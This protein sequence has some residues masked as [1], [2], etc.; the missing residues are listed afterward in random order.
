MFFGGLE[1]V[2]RGALLK[3]LSRFGGLGKSNFLEISGLYAS[4]LCKFL[5]LFFI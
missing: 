1:G 3:F 4:V 2:E 5:L